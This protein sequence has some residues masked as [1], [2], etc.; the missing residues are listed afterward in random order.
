MIE[1]QKEILDKATIIDDSI[2]KVDN[3]INHKI[4]IKLLG[5]ICDLIYSEFKHLEINKI[6]TVET[7]GIAMATLLATKFSNCDVVY[8]KKAKSAIHNKN[9]CYQKTIT[10]FTKKTTTNISIN[11]NYL[12]ESDNVLIVD[13]F[14]ATGDV[15]NGLINLCN[16]ADANV[17]GIAVIINKSF[18]NSK[19]E[20]NLIPFSIVNITGIE[21]GFVKYM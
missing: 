18:Q 19:L 15:L 10:S 17:N 5:K 9:E 11:H 12:N 4:D 1:L 6:I 14:L 20:T 16:Q 7:G 13:D 8:A 21:N 2:V 3:I